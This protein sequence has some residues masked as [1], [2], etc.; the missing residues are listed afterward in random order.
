MDS[1]GV[2]SALFRSVMEFNAGE[3]STGLPPAWEGIKDYK[4]KRR[5][6]AVEK[7]GSVGGLYSRDMRERQTRR[8]SSHVGV[9]LVAF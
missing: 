5:G 9:G 1:G 8:S 6:T 4:N 2:I 7:I 3:R